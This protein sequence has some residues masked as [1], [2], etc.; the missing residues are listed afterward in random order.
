MREQHNL[1]YHLIKMPWVDWGLSIQTLQLLP[2][3]VLDLGFTLPGS[4]SVLIYSLLKVF[5][6]VR[7]RSL[8]HVYGQWIVRGILDPGDQS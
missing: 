2:S 7:P 1:T 6:T 3:R 5:T 8:V 4:V